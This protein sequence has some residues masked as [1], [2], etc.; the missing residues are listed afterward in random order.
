MRR[1]L[2][3]LGS[4]FAFLPALAQAE[5]PA[6]SPTSRVVKTF[7]FEEKALGN[8]EPLPM[9]WNRVV[10]AG[11]PLYTGGSF[12]TSTFRSASTSFK[13]QL[14]GGSVAYQ[15]APGRLH[16]VPGADY[17]ILAYVKTTHLDFARAQLAAWFADDAGHP[18]EATKVASEPYASDD[19]TD[20]HLLH[21]YLPGARLTQRA[22]LILQVGLLQPEKFGDN[23]LGKFELYHQDITGSAWFD[24]ISIL[25][26]PRVSLTT[27]SPG[28]LAVPDHPLSFNMNVSDL[29]REHL[30]ASFTLADLDGH[31]LY[32]QQWPVTYVAGG[33]WQHDLTLPANSL[34]AGLYT[35]TLDV[36]DGKSTV[37][38]R[39]LTF[40]SLP[41]AA[42][43]A[44]PAPE[45][46][47]LADAWPMEAWQDLPPILQQLG[48]GLV[49]FPA[50]RP[51]MSEDALVT[52]DPVFDNL[53]DVLNKA[54][55]T[56]LARFSQIPDTLAAK[57]D[58]HADGVLSLFTAD[59]ALWRPALSFLL[60]RDSSKV[61]YWE[62]GSEADSF[63][64]PTTRHTAA[65]ATLQ[66][67]LA[68]ILNSRAL[69]IPWNALY[70]FDAKSFP[71]AVLELHLPPVIHPSQIPAYIHN[72]QSPTT[73]VLAV[74]DTPEDATTPRAD[75][76]A[77]YAQRILM[78][79]SANPTATLVDL[80]LTRAA[81]LANG[82]DQPSELLLV[83]R[84]LVTHLGGAT[85]KKD[86]PLS[87]G[88]SANKAGVHALLFD[89]NGSGLLALW[90]DSP[91][92]AP[93]RLSALPGHAVTLTTILGQ[94]SDVLLTND[95]CK[96]SLTSTPI[97]L[98]GIDTQS[99]QLRASFALSTPRL[100]AGTGVVDTRV[101][102][103]NP[104]NE[105]L[106]GS[107]H[108]F[109]PAGWRIEPSVIAI[110]LAPNAKLDHP[111]TV[112]YPFSEFA[113]VKKITAV[114]TPDGVNARPVDLST[115]VALTSDTVEMECLAYAGPHGDIILQQ[116]L[117]NV[118]NAPLDARAYAM[119]P[120][121]AREER[122]V[123]DLKPGET[124]IKRYTFPNAADLK[125]KLGV[126]G[127]KLN[128]GT[129]LLTQA[130]RM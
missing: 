68:P 18:I 94:S 54:S 60:S 88:A 1:L 74:I 104:N 92:P 78:T 90:N 52:K 63:W 110:A 50:W 72:F 96:L 13:L 53:L 7:D 32:T 112:R 40:A 105:T 82:M 58:K 8:Y 10:G 47:V 5:A 91:N 11:Y 130:V 61:R 33:A 38:R 108:L 44:A 65:F 93:L 85:F 89:R 64:T 111:I 34:P 2:P 115:H 97:L 3:I 36:V 81:A 30:A 4:L 71:N 122:F 100:P 31:A 98:E 28:N 124:T 19:S 121:A 83:Y 67:E 12:D 99:L 6:P 9:F 126:M 79:R 17:Y 66:T 45:F 56:T 57:L 76:L 48:V 120:G 129:I 25:Q 117:T 95:S 123:V 15:Y 62:L 73:P 23:H 70:D 77:D 84:S 113:G 102:L 37:A 101:L 39:Q 29:G 87:A 20:W 128:D 75:R 24:D 14:D 118:S 106:T 114:F 107:L 16:I 109:G 46:G 42:A 80:P 49:A 26:L 35:G 55:I 116:M 103:E 41:H 125:S 22:S 119:V 27:A 59:S 127:L 43:D 21:L 86:L 51:N 69:V